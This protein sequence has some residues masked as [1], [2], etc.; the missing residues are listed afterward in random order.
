MRAQIRY[1]AF[2][3]S[4][5]NQA[6]SGLRKAVDDA[7]EGGLDRIIDEITGAQ[8]AVDEKYTVANQAA[9]EVDIARGVVQE[10]YDEYTAA[11]D[12][13]NADINVSITDQATADARLAK[14]DAIKAR[15]GCI[16]KQL[17]D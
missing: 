12:K 11:I 3:A 13:Y 10:I 7:T 8:A 16:C 1:Q 4:F 2:Q 17:S 15:L 9:A 14:I 5:N 6:I